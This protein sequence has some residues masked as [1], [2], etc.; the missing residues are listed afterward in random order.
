MVQE[1]GD[2]KV[3]LCK[4]C[5]GRSGES[6]WR[7]A[8]KPVCEILWV[9]AYWANCLESVCSLLVISTADSEL[10]KLCS[11]LSSSVSL[12][13]KSKT[14]GV[15]KLELVNS[16]WPSLT[17]GSINISYY[18]LK[19]LIDFWKTVFCFWYPSILLS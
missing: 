19:L 3:W 10:G 9:K 1:G 14:F 5:S 13:N 7:R 4:G 18:Y 15:T 2:S 8:V 11:S 6:K 12:E 17:M 16:L